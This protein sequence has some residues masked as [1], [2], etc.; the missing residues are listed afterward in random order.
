MRRKQRRRILSI[1]VLFLLMGGA[2][3][4]VERSEGTLQGNELLRGEPGSGL[5]EETLYYELE[6]DDGLHAF[7]LQVPSRKL[8]GKE[9]E[10]LLPAASREAEL[11]FL[12]E[13]DTADH[14]SGK[15]ELCETLQGGL[16]RV[17]WKITPE[18]LIDPEGTI[19]EERLAD[20]GGTMAMVT[21]ELSC[22]D[23]RVDYEFPVC[24][25]PEEKSWEEKL[26]QQINEHIRQQEESLP[27]IELPEEINGQKIH[28]QYP[29]TY[30]L[31]IFAGLGTA[32]AVCMALTEKEKQRRQYR[33]RKK[34]LLMDYPDI[35]SR[36]GLL[37]EAGMPLSA[38]WERLVQTYERRRKDR[39]GGRRE[40]YEEMLITLHELQDGMGERRAL[41]Q[42]GDRCQ[43][44]Q[45][46]R[47]ASI[48]I[49]NMR[50]GT[51]GIGAILSKEAADAFLQRRNEAQRLGEEAG[52]K[53]LFPM[54]LMLVVVMI[55]LIV[56]ACMTIQ[57]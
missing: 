47:F 28:W 1:L 44:P 48:L 21:A 8:S 45:Y 23:F 36:L 53:L 41:E 4:Y 46:R 19:Q 26:A 40:G 27:T 35:V 43:T 9:W 38:A 33:Q 57:I 30:T 15:V 29:R 37:L 16:V 42:F 5:R 39:A 49:Q 55:I 11:S 56:P 22:G 20:E 25:Y 6:Q 18:D 24:L 31:W 2:A 13:N 7:E 51:A 17:T 54:M 32:A 34:R 52:T 3:V 12:G 14:V 50:K 10:E